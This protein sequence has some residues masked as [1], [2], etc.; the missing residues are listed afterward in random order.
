MK[1]GKLL[2]N[3]THDKVKIKSFTNNSAKVEKGD[4]FVAIKGDKTD[5]HNYIKDA[6]DRGASIIICEKD[7][8]FKNQLIVENSKAAYA[9]MCANYFKNPAEK[10]KLIGVTGTNGKTTITYLYKQI[11]EEAG[12]K[13]GLIGTINNHVGDKVYKSRLTTPDAFELHEL[14]SKMVK[15]GC[16]YV[17]MEVSSHALDQKR[18][19]GL[20]FHQAIF[21]NLTQD[22]LDYHGTME[23]YLNA[24]KRLFKMCDNAIMNFDDEYCEKM[25]EGLTAKVYSYAVNQIADFMGKDCRFTPN[26]TSFMLVDDNNLTK[27]TLPTLGLF[28]VYNALA[29]TSGARLLGISNETIA[30]ALSKVSV[31]GRVEI[32]PTSRDFTAVIDYAHTPDGLENILNALNR[33][34][35]GRLVALFGCGGDRDKTKRPLMGATAARLSDKIII[36]SDN[37]RNEDPKSIID[38]ILAGIKK[39]ACEVEVIENRTEAIHSVIKTAKPNDIIVLCGKGHETYQILKDETIDLDEREVIKQALQSL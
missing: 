36:T 4:A 3:T 12:F 27:I 10:L 34:K 26:G 35:Q 1:L 31:K 14:F 24:K 8:G 6:I 32:V 18:A 16:K 17:V 22:H 5:G 28:S 13:T 7:S 39:P 37:P 15:A 23:N 19:H 9:T 21:T 38:D 11:L 20:H 30:K 29:V 25:R 2:P 33:V